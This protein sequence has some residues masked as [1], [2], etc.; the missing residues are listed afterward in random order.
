MSILL[1]LLKEVVHHQIAKSSS[2]CACNLLMLFLQ[3]LNFQENVDQEV[4]SYS[5]VAAILPVMDLDHQ[6]LKLQFEYLLIPYFVNLAVFIGLTDVQV[7]PLYSSV[8]LV[9]FGDP[10]AVCSTKS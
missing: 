5:S 6:K 1:L 4:P 10:G 2:L 3:Y 8:A 7:E 9:K